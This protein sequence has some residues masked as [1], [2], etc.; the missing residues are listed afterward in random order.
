VVSFP[1]SRSYCGWHKTIDTSDELNV[2]VLREGLRF[3][4]VGSACCQS[5]TVQ[6]IDQDAVTRAGEGHVRVLGFLVCE[7]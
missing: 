7:A 1:R 2:T 5:P 3:H 4:H 6:G